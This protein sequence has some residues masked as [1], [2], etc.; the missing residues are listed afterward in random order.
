MATA[1]IKCPQCGSRHVVSNITIRWNQVKGSFLSERGH[2]CFRC[3]RPF[4]Q[5]LVGDFTFRSVRVPGATTA[6][7]SLQA[8]GDMIVVRYRNGATEVLF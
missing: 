8:S 6:M 2:F 4:Q 5:A 3:G 1:G 7:H